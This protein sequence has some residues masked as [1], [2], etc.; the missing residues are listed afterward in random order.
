MAGGGDVGATRT[1]ALGFGETAGKRW[2]V[3][4]DYPLTSFLLV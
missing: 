3:S 4:C 2:C 1:P